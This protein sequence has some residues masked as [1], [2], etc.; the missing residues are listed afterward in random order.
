MNAFDFNLYLIVI[1]IYLNHKINNV[2][3]IQEKQQELFESEKKLN[4]LIAFCNGKTD[5]FCSTQS[6]YY[7]FLILKSEREYEEKIK[8]LKL[9]QSK[10]NN[11]ILKYPRYR[12]LGEILIERFFK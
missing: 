6:L 8:K 4:I 1:I 12:F 7:M 11:F 5:N 2:Q 3:A 10:I 9:E